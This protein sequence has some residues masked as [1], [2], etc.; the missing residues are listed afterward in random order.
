MRLLLCGFLITGSGCQALNGAYHGAERDLVLAADAMA[1]V[2]DALPAIDRPPPL[3]GPDSALT[4]RRPFLATPPNPQE[5][6][7]KQHLG[8]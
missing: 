4:A 3:R 2:A 1:R 5:R 7:A 8:W 6:M